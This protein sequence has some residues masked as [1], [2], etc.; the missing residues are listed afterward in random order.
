[1]R[2]ISIFA[3]IICLMTVTAQAEPYG[4]AM[5]GAPKYTKDSPHLDY[6]NPDAPK[7]GHLTRAA[8]GRFD[9]LNPLTIKGNAAQGLGLTTDR[10]MARVWD[11]PFT[12]YPLIAERYDIADDRSWIR[13]HLNPAARFHDGSPIHVADVEFSF[14]TLKAYGR[15]NMR[16][17][18][19]LVDH[20]DKTKHSITFYF[21]AGYDQETA[22]ILA[23]MPVLSRAYWEDKTFD[24]TTL[25]PPLSNGPYKIKSIDPGRSITYERVKN[26]WAADHLT[27]KG[28]NNFDEITYEYFRDEGVAF[29]AFKSGR[30]SLWLEND[31][32]RWMSSY[33][34]P[35]VHSGKIEREDILHQRPEK[36]K[37][38]IFNT[39]R[40]PFDDIRVRKAL[41]LLLDEYWINKNLFHNQYNR[42][43]S[44]YPNSELSAES[45]A[46]EP[47]YNRRT[48]TREA[49]Q[50]LD[51]AG[52]SVAQN[53]KRIK[54][55]KSLSFEILLSS[56]DDE[57][58]ALIFKRALEKAGITPQIRVLDRAAYLARMNDYDFDMSLYYWQSS[59]SPGTE[60]ILYYNCE[61]AK[62]KARWNFPG[63]C[64]DE[65]DRLTHQI[66][67]S[68]D[69]DSLVKTVKALDAQLMTGHYMIPLF[70][71]GADHYAY[72]QPIKH[73]ENT[74]IYGAVL[75]TWWMDQN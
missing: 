12:M 52:W 71:S 27:R 56:P 37:G 7:G 1:M 5:H 61:S 68:T 13:F 57:K 32:A 21:G 9:T 75:E 20:I 53:K 22:L 70:Y 39:R 50:L 58:I 28:V 33:N 3:F 25:T 65:I 14:E 51:E 54:D 8:I 4:L 18:Y 2:L 55:G 40:P 17:I 48:S 15:P 19:K 59:L 72:W 64:T 11:E 74:P 66:A 43:K 49:Y 23:M 67:A 60:Q 36:A 69:R 30:L 45:Y 26:Y 73:P 34:I 63:I 29:E 35:A 46:A 6:A 31:I 41:G 38:F 10:L 47:P 44:Y 62:Q 42:I 24:E 16:R